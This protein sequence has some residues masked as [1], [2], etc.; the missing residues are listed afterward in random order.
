MSPTSCGVA[1]CTNPATDRIRFGPDAATHF[2]GVVCADHKT[3]IDA[4]A[5]VRWE[6]DPTGGSP[7]ALVMG[8]ELEGAGLTVTEVIAVEEHGL[9]LARD[10]GPVVTLVLEKLNA[11]ASREELRLTMSYEVMDQL[12]SIFEV[13]WRRRPDVGLRAA[14]RRV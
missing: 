11:D 10:S 12:G 14:R 3:Q 1:R 4:G 2:E 7:G 6:R 13:Y 8:T 9:V 5:P